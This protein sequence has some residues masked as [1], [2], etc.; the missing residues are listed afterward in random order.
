MKSQR[1]TIET[2]P[3]ARGENQIVEEITDA[4]EADDNKYPSE[5]IG[6]EHGEITL[7][8]CKNRTMSQQPQYQS[9]P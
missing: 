8:P 1:K 9:E 4:G 6:C 7:G 3:Q 5:I 2:N